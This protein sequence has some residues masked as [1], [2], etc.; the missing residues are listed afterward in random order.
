MT[1]SCDDSDCSST[2]ETTHA[3]DLKTGAPFDIGFYSDGTPAML[4]LKTSGPILLECLDLDCTGAN[5]YTP[6]DFSTDLFTSN[7]SLNLLIKGDDTA[8]F[9]YLNWGPENQ[10][11]IG[12]KGVGARNCTSIAENHKTMFASQAGGGYYS[13]LALTSDGLPV[14]AYSADG[15]ISVQFCEDKGNEVIGN[16]SSS[17]YFEQ[18]EDFKDIQ[19][20]LTDGDVPIITAIRDDAGDTAIVLTCVDMSCSDAHLFDLG[21][22]MEA[23]TNLGEDQFWTIAVTDLELAS[24]PN[25]RYM[26]YGARTSDGNVHLRV[27]QIIAPAVTGIVPAS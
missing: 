5:Q 19:V 8:M 22:G 27:G 6:G 3:Q 2:T 21:G 24:S 17:I 18:G 16:G 1:V 13:D 15:H 25:G 9:S 4:T 7:S 12:C 10:V 14:F 11:L 20:R 26:A 23:H